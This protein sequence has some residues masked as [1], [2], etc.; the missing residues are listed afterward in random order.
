MAKGKIGKGVSSM[1]VLVVSQPSLRYEGLRVG[2]M[3]GVLHCCCPT[4]YKMSSCGNLKDKIFIIIIIVQLY[5]E[6]EPD[7]HR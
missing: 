5:S 1:S 3:L 2:E 6:V 4:S 7:I